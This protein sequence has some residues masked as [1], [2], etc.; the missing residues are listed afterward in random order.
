M[1]GI[2]IEIREKGIPRIQE[3]ILRKI[4]EEGGSHLQRILEISIHQSIGDAWEGF[5]ESGSY[6]L[7]E[8]PGIPSLLDLLEE[9][10]WIDSK[11]IEIGIPDLLMDLRDDLISRRMEEEKIRILRREI[12][13]IREGM[14]EGGFRYPSLQKSILNADQILQDL[15]RDREG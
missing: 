3:E 11:E 5:Q 1:I 13:E 10:S 12:R 8:I 2:G 4:R 14:K 6:L 9:I 15:R 7:E